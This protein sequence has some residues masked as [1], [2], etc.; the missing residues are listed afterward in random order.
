M[1]KYRDRW[2]SV[3][4]G[5]GSIFDDDAFRSAALDALDEIIARLDRIENE[6]KPRA[7]ID[8]GYKTNA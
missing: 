2:N 1:G 3:S 4:T 6:T 8:E 7:K 5:T